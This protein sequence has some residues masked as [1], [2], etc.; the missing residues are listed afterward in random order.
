M[1]SSDFVKVENYDQYKILIPKRKFETSENLGEFIR[2]F[3]QL[4]ESDDKNIAL[5][6]AEIE[7]APSSIIGMIMK[8]H[9][10]F[11]QIEKKLAVL[12]PHPKLLNILQASGVNKI[13]RIVDKKED[14]L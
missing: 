3:N 13:L 7:Y 10:E 4:I 6:F 5:D 14:L 8:A 1:E 2:E 12:R 9:K 11:E